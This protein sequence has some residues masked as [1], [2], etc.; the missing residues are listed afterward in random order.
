MRLSPTVLTIVPLF[1]SVACNTGPA[2]GSAEAGAASSRAALRP[3][4]TQPTE[5]PTPPPP[6]FTGTL[7]VDRVVSAQGLLHG[8]EPYGSAYGKL[9][10]LLG[11]PI[12]TVHKTH[13]LIGKNQDQYQWAATDGHACASYFAIQNPDVLGGPGMLSEDFGGKKVDMP[14]K[15]ATSDWD[16]RNRLLREWDKYGECLAILG[17]KPGLPPDDPKGAGPNAKVTKPELTRGLEAAPGKWIGKTVTVSGT[18]EGISLGTSMM[19]AT[20]GNPD[21]KQV[22]LCKVPK[23]ET[24]PEQKAPKAPVTV[25]GKVNDPRSWGEENADLFDCHLV[26]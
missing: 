7:T 2:T 1:V 25:T 8:M 5:P 18:Y 11:T 9:V 16:E 4:V 21:A 17:Q 6:P 14:A 3:L 19:V 12:K 24:P 23:G 15:V 26:R 22:L 10:G 13:A 20:A